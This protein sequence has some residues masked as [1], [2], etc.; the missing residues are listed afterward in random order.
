MG[1]KAAIVDGPI[2]PDLFHRLDSMGFEIVDMNDRDAMKELRHR[3]HIEEKSQRKD[4]MGISD[5]KGKTLVVVGHWNVWDVARLAVLEHRLPPL[6]IAHR[7]AEPVNLPSHHQRLA[8][9]ILAYIPAQIPEVIIDKNK[10][11]FSPWDAFVGRGTGRPKSQKFAQH[12]NK[13][14]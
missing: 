9:E 4:E 3:L 13:R 5:L 10:D 2:S 1:I 11:R 14:S 7:N 12:F 8:T 6:L